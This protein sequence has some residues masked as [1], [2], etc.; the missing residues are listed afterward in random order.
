MTATVKFDLSKFEMEL[1]AHINENAEVIAKQI[2]RDARASTAFQDYKG[3]AR[4]SNWSKKTWG[5][6]ARKLRKSIRAKR[7]K[8]D[9]GGW[10]VQATAPHAHLIE[11]GHGGPSPA[12][13]HPFLRP[14]LEK[15]I[16]EARRQF[17]AK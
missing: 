8:F 1:A 17:G 16:T 11:Y 5:P 4:E 15:N 12:P 6:N 10:I 9:D 7:S 13:P 14:A 2:A 3:T